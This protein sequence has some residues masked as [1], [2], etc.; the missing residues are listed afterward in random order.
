MNGAGR[1]VN[2]R[3]VPYNVQADLLT[4]QVVVIVEH[5]VSTVNKNSD[6]GERDCATITTVSLPLCTLF[7]PTPRRPSPR[8]CCY[9]EAQPLALFPRLCQ[10][11]IVL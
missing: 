3:N 1:S 11:L 7:Q 2:C 10:T 6:G 9:H 5:V 8:A 4:E